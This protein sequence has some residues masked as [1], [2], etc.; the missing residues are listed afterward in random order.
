ML[1]TCW[2][3]EDDSI[4]LLWGIQLQLVNG[5]MRTFGNFLRFDLFNRSKGSRL[6]VLSAALLDG[7]QDVLLLTDKESPFLPRILKVERAEVV[8]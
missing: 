7:R 2:R 4:A 8:T 5:P 6:R 1:M 3:D